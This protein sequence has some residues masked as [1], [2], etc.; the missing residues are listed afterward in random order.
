MPH[1]NQPPA[2]RAS[3]PPGQAREKRRA[4]SPEREAPLRVAA[5]RPTKMAQPKRHYSHGHF[6]TRPEIQAAPGLHRFPR[7]AA[8]AEARQ[9]SGA[10]RAGEPVSGRNTRSVPEPLP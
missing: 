8:T 3:S 7:S 1:S 9:S 2:T 5:K 4:E 10:V 6:H